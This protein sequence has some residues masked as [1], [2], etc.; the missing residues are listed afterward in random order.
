MPYSI[1]AQRVE[2]GMQITFASIPYAQKYKVYR[3]ATTDEK[4]ISLGYT[5]NTSFID[6]TGV[7]GVKYIYTVRAINGN[8]YSNYYKQP[9][10]VVY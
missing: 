3:K 1:K 2:S 8:S 6:T 10:T 5:N 9:V 4:W 7:S